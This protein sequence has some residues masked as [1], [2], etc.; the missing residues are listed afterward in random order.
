M[1]FISL[2]VF[3][4]ASTRV[5]DGTNASISL[6]PPINRHGKCNNMCVVLSLHNRQKKYYKFY[7]EFSQ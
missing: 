1:E 7:E 3:V 4:S 5:G 2:T 6:R